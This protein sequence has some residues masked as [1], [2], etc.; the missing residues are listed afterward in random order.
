MKNESAVTGVM[1]FKAPLATTGIDFKR[2]S[3]AIDS[4]QI[5]SEV[6]AYPRFCLKF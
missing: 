3:M 5:S 1:T 4:P 6:L 2:D